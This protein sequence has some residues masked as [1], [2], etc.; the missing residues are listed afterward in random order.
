[1]DLHDSADRLNAR[2]A[3]LER[4]LA[5]LPWKTTACVENEDGDRLWF[6]HHECQWRLAWELA[7]SH[8]N[9]PSAASQQQGRSPVAGAT[10]AGEN[11]LVPLR[12][13]PLHLKARAVTLLP[14]LIDAMQREFEDSVAAVARAHGALDAVERRLL[15]SAT[16]HT[17]SDLSPRSTSPIPFPPTAA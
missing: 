7:K 12:E 10:P 8:P 13:C 16:H 9:A 1:M 11:A 5:L 3:Q 2:V 6:A 17:S 4:T 14:Q 15:A